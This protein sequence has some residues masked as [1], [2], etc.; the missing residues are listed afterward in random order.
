M[1]KLSRSE[2]Y[3]L[4][5]KLL[6]SFE[7]GQ[8]LMEELQCWFDN[9]PENLKSSERG[10]AIDEAINQ[11]YKVCDNLVDALTKKIYFPG[12]CN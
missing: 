3:E 1:K 8:A 7:Q 2:R 4:A 5:L 6:E 9:M 12:A 11:L 10:Q